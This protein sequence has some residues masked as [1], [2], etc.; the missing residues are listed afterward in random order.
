MFA[1]FLLHCARF[2]RK[3]FTSNDLDLQ[4]CHKAQCR[5][6]QHR[7]K[8]V[9]GLQRTWGATRCTLFASPSP[10][11]WLCKLDRNSFCK[12]DFYT[13][14]NTRPLC[15]KGYFAGNQRQVTKLLSECLLLKHQSSFSQFHLL[16]CKYRKSFM[17]QISRHLTFWFWIAVGNWDFL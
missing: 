2:W 3:S 15:V 4:N 7:I 5:P 14:V 8:Q 13:A 17:P 10:P 16:T 11:S 6:S 12:V 9:G 1:L